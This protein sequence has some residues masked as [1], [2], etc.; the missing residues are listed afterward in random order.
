MPGPPSGDEKFV[1]CIEF[2]GPLTDDQ[3][4]KIRKDLKNCVNKSK[5]KIVEN[6][7]ETQ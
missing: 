3:L 4:D 5:G 2:N 1:V 6:R 7:V